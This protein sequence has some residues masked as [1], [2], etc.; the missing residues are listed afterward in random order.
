MFETAR[1]KRTESKDY[2]FDDV[3]VDEFVD[4][5]C[6]TSIR[7][8]FV[9]LQAL[10]SILMYMADLAIMGL[11]FYTQISKELSAQCPNDPTTGLSLCTEKN[12]FWSNRI[13]P[14]EYRP[15]I[16]L[17]SVLMSFLFLILDWR[18]ALK[19]IQSRGVSVAFTS[20]I[21]NRFYSL[22]SYA[23]FCLFAEI[24]SSRKALEVVAF[25]V[26]FLLKGWKRLLLAELP[27]QAINFLSLIDVVD[28]QRK[29]SKFGTT[30]PNVR[31]MIESAGD[32]FT[33]PTVVMTQKIYYG[34]QIVTVAIWSVSFSLLLFAMILWI[35]LA[36]QIR[37]N[38]KEYIV[39]IVDKRLDKLLKKRAVDE[40]SDADTY[41]G[42][43]TPKNT[44]PREKTEYSMKSLG[45]PNWP[46]TDPVKLQVPPTP[47]VHHQHPGYN[48]S[49]QQMHQGQWGHYDHHHLAPPPHMMAG[50]PSPTVSS[51]SGTMVL[52]PYGTPEE[53]PSPSVTRY[54]TVPPAAAVAQTMTSPSSGFARLPSPA[55]P[56]SRL[57][58]PMPGSQ[59]PPQHGQG[60]SGYYQ[61]P[62]PGNGGPAYY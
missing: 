30:T 52:P 5:S 41:T 15:Y 46:A 29:Q 51:G 19:V 18:K 6:L 48:H 22:R 49:H 54:T 39:H 23:H 26:F 60:P 8:P 16:Q 53:F 36:M 42:R 1:W 2:K 7:Y 27:R 31:L 59:Y 45:H 32:L 40:Q 37:G 13:L 14:Y 9:Y 33:S 24:R 35:P 44:L 11:L 58:S 3:N 28:I 61:Q 17:V 47:Y 55:P 62:P 25:S 56:A 4:H 20:N 12:G 21:A 57:P 50:P 34:L 10:K 43:D 38:L